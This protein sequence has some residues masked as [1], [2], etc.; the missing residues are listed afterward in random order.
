MSR[1]LNLAPAVPFEALAA[2]PVRERMAALRLAAPDAADAVE[3]VT[4]DPA[5][6]ILWRT[7][8]AAVIVTLLDR[9][10]ALMCLET[11]SRT[12]VT[13]ALRLAHLPFNDFRSGW[14][15]RTRTLLDG[16]EPEHAVTGLLSHP[17][18]T[19]QPDVVAGWLG[20]LGTA[21]LAAAVTRLVTGVDTT[22]AGIALAADPAT[23]SRVLLDHLAESAPVAAGA[24]SDAVDRA[25]RQ[26]GEICDALARLAVAL[27]GR[28]LL[29]D[30]AHRLTPGA[31]RVLLHSGHPL[32]AG[33][34]TASGLLD[35]DEVTGVYDTAGPA[36]RNEILAAAPTSALADRLAVTWEYH[37]AQAGG[38]A[39]TVMQAHPVLTMPARLRLMHGMTIDH[40][41]K[42][43]FDG[44]HGWLAGQRATTVDA[45]FTAAGAGEAGT[46]P[47]RM[48]D[49]RGLAVE[50]CRRLAVSRSRTF[51]AAE[52]EIAAALAE[53]GRGVADVLLEQAGTLPGRLHL[54]AI[55]GACGTDLELFATIVALADGW[56][57]TVGELIE[58]ARLT[59]T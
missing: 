41:V 49:R 13:A 50:I 11:E 51:T 6:L 15:A 4:A 55:T 37:P 23:G 39:V 53:S 52:S 47:W 20:T 12:K 58:A 21:D 10:T 59:T 32:L 43:L 33:Y 24:V 31:A 2:L 9:V 25:I 30:A 1:K 48:P 7:D 34:A 26:R 57:G 42:A 18:G 8:A 28:A 14:C 35:D 22:I 19:W 16:A 17:A 3:Q 36:T 27:G 45:L 38:H 54:A 5:D 46:G 29:S 56:D 40:V 44:A